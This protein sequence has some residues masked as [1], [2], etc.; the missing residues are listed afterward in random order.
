MLDLDIR[1]QVEHSSIV[2]QSQ[3]TH[4]EQMTQQKLAQKLVLDGINSLQQ[5]K[6]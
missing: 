3:K 2:V 4:G 6:N 1:Q 5:Q